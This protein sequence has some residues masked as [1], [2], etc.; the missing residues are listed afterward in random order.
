VIGGVLSGAALPAPA[1]IS[2]AP[3]SPIRVGGKL[4]AP[5]LISAPDPVY[6]ILARQG[7]ISGAVVIDAVIDAQE[8]VVEMRA[9]SGQPILVLAATEA[10]RHWKYEPTILGGEAIPVQLLVTITFVRPQA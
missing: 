2:S 9:V 10:L 4:K 1:P 7:K 6:P 3:K 8:N 5:R